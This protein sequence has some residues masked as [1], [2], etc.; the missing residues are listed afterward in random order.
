MPSTI[1]VL[2]KRLY[3]TK[4]QRETN[5]RAWVFRILVNTYISSYRKTVRQPQ[6]I[7][8][9]DVDEMLQETVIEGGQQFAESGEK[10]TNAEFDDDISD[11]LK[12]LPYP[13]RLAVLLCDVEEFS[14]HE[15]SGILKSVAV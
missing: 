15:I 7:S 5:F 6:R 4:F 3:G 9:D 2:W 1:K 11:A 13:F 12:K 8:Y 10:F 14:Y